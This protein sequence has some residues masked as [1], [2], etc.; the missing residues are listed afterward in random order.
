MHTSQTTASDHDSFAIRL[1]EIDR[2]IG[3]KENSYTINVN[4]DIISNSLNEGNTMLIEPTIASDNNDPSE[5]ILSHP[6][7]LTSQR[8]PPLNTLLIKQYSKEEKMEEAG[9]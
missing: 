6:S 1:A 4:E 5:I 3:F 9:V 2:E 8:E 7:N